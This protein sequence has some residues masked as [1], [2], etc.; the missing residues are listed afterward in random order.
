L[1]DLDLTIYDAARIGAEFRKKLSPLGA[2][3]TDEVEFYVRTRQVQ[4][5]S[6]AS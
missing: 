1:R 2:S 3:M 6:I 5:N 4:H